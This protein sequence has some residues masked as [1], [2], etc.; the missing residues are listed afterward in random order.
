MTEE[1]SEDL[2][3]K[4]HSLQ[5]DQDCVQAARS[6]G[7]ATFHAPCKEPS[8][9][10]YNR[11]P[12]GFYASHP[13]TQEHRRQ[14]ETVARIRLA[15]KKEEEAQLHM[16]ACSPNACE[17]ERGWGRNDKMKRRRKR[18]QKKRKKK[19]KQKKKKK[20]KT[21]NRRRRKNNK[22]INL[23]EIKNRGS[24]FCSYYK[25]TLLLDKKNR[26]HNITKHVLS[27]IF[28]CSFGLQCEG[29]WASHSHYSGTLETVPANLTRAS[30]QCQ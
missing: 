10:E 23:Q 2:K 28:F 17:T 7:M 9:E 11:T 18:K 15:K 12:L 1:L 3:A 24:S 14:L 25:N 5:I 21:K 29:K 16:G 4:T 30:T 6:M 13:E 19:R 20:K 22:T 26:L 27:G 8:S